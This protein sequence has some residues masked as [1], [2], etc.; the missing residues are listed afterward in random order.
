MT[1]GAATPDAVANPRALR[2]GGPGRSA[3]AWVLNNGLLLVL[4][5]ELLIF[6]VVL[7]EKFFSPEVLVLIVQNS[8]VVGLIMP[9][10]ACAL[11][12]GVIDLS[13]VSLGNLCALVF[14]VLLLPAIG[15]PWG[16]AL[17]AAL[18][19]VMLIA[20]FST[21]LIT[22]VGVPALVATLAMGAILS[23]LAYVMTDLFGSTFGQIKITAPLL[24]NLV[25]KG[26]L[27]TGVAMPVFLMLLVYLGYYVI[28]NHTRF[29]AHMYA[30]GGSRQ[31]AYLAGI[32]ATPIVAFCLTGIAVGTG[33]ASIFLGA[34]LL[35]TGAAVTFSAAATSSGASA[36]PVP[37]VAAVI[38]GISLS[39]GSG[40]MERTLLGVLFFSVMTIGMGVL[41]L[42]PQVRVT[43]EGAAI[44][45]A[46]I[47]DGLRQHVENR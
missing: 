39:G 34:R 30:L 29:G 33:L 46:I 17:I 18:L 21:W 1:V 45:L 4:L 47:L 6:S 10:Y 42:P 44:V 38:A 25:S 14:A 11:I 43:I 35:T 15:L 36:I 13:V 5:L 41:N 37:L 27:G 12:A 2:R 26:F 28:L 24:R 23:G 8:A 3:L 40:R 32:R 20:L 9:F 7:K 19:A 16:A 31:A 22:R